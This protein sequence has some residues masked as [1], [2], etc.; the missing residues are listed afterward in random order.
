MGGFFVHKLVG[1]TGLGLQLHKLLLLILLTTPENAPLTFGRHYGWILLSGLL[2][3]LCLTG[4]LLLAS[5]L[6]DLRDA[7]AWRIPAAMAG[8]AVLESFVFAYYY[9]TTCIARCHNQ[10]AAVP[11]QRQR[12]KTAA[13][14]TAFPHGKTPNSLV[15][16]IVAGTVTICS[17]TMLLYGIRDFGSL[18]L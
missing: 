8:C 11:S 5:Y 2:S 15:S 16:N 17:S 1:G 12:G 13:A 14:V 4:F 9:A 7:D 10:K 6:T 18:R 3:D